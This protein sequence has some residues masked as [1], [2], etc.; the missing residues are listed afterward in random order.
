MSDIAHDQS[1]N[2]NLSKYLEFSARPELCNKKE[3]K[4]TSFYENKV[5]LI[6]QYPKAP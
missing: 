5:L 3:K 1:T 4:S 6:A 2:K